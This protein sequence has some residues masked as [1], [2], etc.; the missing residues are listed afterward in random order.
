MIFLSTTCVFA[1][2]NLSFI[3]IN[4]SNNNDTKMKKWYEDGVKKLHPTLR[5]KFLTNR[6]IDNYFEEKGGFDIEKEPVIFFWGYKS[7]N[8]LDFVKNN[9]EISKKVS[10]KGSYI[11]R[12]MLTQFLHDAIWVQKSH[13]MIPI[14][15][16]L[17]ELVKKETANGNKVILYGYSAGTFI[18]YEY[19]FNKTRYIDLAETLEIAEADSAYVKYAKSKPAKRTCISALSTDYSGIATFSASGKVFLN[20][21]IEDF[22]KRYSNLDKFTEQA[23]AP[24]DKLLG[25]VNFASPL[26]LF[27]SDIEDSNYE[28]SNFNRFMAKYIYE[29]GL[30]FLTINFKEDPLGYPTGRNITYDDLEDMIGLKINNPKGFVYDASWIPSRRLFPFAHTSYWSA[31]RSFANGITKNLVNGYKFQ[32]DE[33]YQAKVIRKNHKNSE[34]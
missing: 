22:K 16:E 18:T 15:D 9:L 4:G 32:Y 2:E 28:L 33:K 5:K 11:V 27:Y 10:S 30:F 14:L 20:P 7:K 29:K 31:K 12:S 3:Y 8:D 17:N 6:G 26:P 1:Q 34:L 25:I 23:C 24:E 13:N 19:L 21:N